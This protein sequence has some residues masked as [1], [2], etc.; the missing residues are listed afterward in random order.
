MA[1]TIADDLMQIRGGRGYE[2]AESLAARGERPIGV[3]QIMRDLRINRIFEGSTEIM[4]LLIARAAVVMLRSVAGDII[5]P[6]AA[7][8]AMV[9]AGLRAGAFYAAWL[10]T[11]AVGKGQIPGGYGSFGPL[12]KHLRVVERSSRKL[13]RSTFY[14][15]ARWH[16]K[17]ERRQAFLGRIVDIGAELFAMSATCVRAH[18][19]RDTHPEGLEL[20]ELFCRQARLRIREHFRALWRN[21]DSRDVALAKRIAEGRYAWIERGVLPVPDTGEW[22]STWEVG[23]S[24]EKDV[25]RRIPTA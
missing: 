17:L 22:V 23:P 16:G 19:E 10:P 9:K 8:G 20:A 14:G 24:T 3:E 2:T 6:E 21:T 12:A 13:A 25:R 4:H 7:T 5:D 18:A 1:W 11:L 15:M